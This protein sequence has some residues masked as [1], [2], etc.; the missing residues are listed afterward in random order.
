MAKK[1]ENL[2]LVLKLKNI[3][4]HEKTDKMTGTF[5]AIHKEAKKK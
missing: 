4:F 2:T 1:E 3:K 5:T